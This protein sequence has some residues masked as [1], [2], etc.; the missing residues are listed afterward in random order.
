MWSFMT[1]ESC[2]VFLFFFC[3]SL[4]FQGGWVADIITAHLCAHFSDQCDLKPPPRPQ[5]RSAPT[6]NSPLAWLLCRA[7]D[8]LMCQ[9]PWSMF[10]IYFWL[11][12]VFVAAGSPSL[13]PA[14]GAYFSLQGMDLLQWRLL[15]GREALEH[16][17]SS[18]RACAQQ[19]HCMWKLPKLGVLGV[20][21]CP[22]H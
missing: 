1:L 20:C 18:C 10:Q 4:F 7:P 13:I 8:L 12:W 19:P 16:S 22:L 14:S 2:G 9:T 3:F 21:V 11:R 5:A 17:L 6:P 15:L